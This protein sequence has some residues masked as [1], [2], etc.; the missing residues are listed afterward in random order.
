MSLSHEKPLFLKLK[1]SQINDCST[2]C[3]CIGLES[4]MSKLQR[5]YRDATQLTQITFYDSL[6]S[7]IT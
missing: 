4:L 1:G 2:V 7:R 6:D 3:G 5:L